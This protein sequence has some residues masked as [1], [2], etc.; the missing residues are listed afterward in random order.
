MSLKI[1]KLDLKNLDQLF[2]ETFTKEQIA[3]AKTLFLKELADTMHRF[4]G[5]KTLPFATTPTH[6]SNFLIAE[7]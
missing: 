5:G 1:D 4:Y 7:T 6:L 2:P 3:E